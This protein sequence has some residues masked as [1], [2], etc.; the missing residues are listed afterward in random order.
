LVLILGFA[1]ARQ[2]AKATSSH[3]PRV[4]V[5]ASL[6]SDLVA[7]PVPNYP[8]EAVEKKCGGLGVFELQFRPNGTVRNVV[9]VLTTEHQLLD[10]TA[11]TSLWQWRSQPLA[12]TSARLTMSF[13][14]D[15]NPRQSG[16]G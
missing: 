2:D 1:L 14:A 15:Y 4:Y 3:W 6:V 9:T 8:M 13:S 16:P 12:Q 5:D 10:D 11:R 7:A